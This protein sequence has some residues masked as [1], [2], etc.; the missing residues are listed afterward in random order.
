MHTMKS[1]NVSFPKGFQFNKITNESKSRATFV[2]KSSKAGGQRHWPHTVST[3]INLIIRMKFTLPSD[4][5]LVETYVIGSLC[6]HFIFS[7]L[8]YLFSRLKV[9]AVLSVKIQTYPVRNF[10]VKSEALQL[11][12]SPSF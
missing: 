2:G 12:I 5:Y 11:Q 4:Y 8:E 1:S 7:H 10:V 9:R 3:T 6:I